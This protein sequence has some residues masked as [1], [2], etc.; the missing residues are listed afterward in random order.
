MENL[1][2]I[3]RSRGNSYVRRVLEKLSQAL[4]ENLRDFDVPGRAGDAE[5]SFLSTIAQ[6]GTAEDIALA[7]LKIELMFPA[8]DATREMLMAMAG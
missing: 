3:A 1:D 8:D 5:F 6:F 2:E 4:R 7:D